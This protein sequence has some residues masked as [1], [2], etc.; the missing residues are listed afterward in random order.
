MLEVLY[1][2]GIRRAEL[3]HLNIRDIDRERSTLM[4]RQGKGKKDRLVPIHARCI[5]WLDTY[6]ADARP[7]LAAEPD[8]GTLFLTVDGTPFSLDRLTQLAVSRASP[9]TPTDFAR[10]RRPRF[11]QISC[12]THLMHSRIQPHPLL[13]C[14]PSRRSPSKRP[15]LRLTRLA[16]R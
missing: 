9:V 7:K 12:A 16:P 4:V 14:R 15:T 13:P 6:L 2:T 1:C 5:T 3:A 8:D 10:P 11:R